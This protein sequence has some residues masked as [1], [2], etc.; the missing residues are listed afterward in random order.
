MSSSSSSS[1]ARHMMDDYKVQSGVSITNDMLPNAPASSLLIV[2]KEAPSLWEKFQADPF[3][4]IGCFV[5]A[6]ILVGG[7]H[8]FWK[9]ESKKS[10]KWMRARVASQGITIGVIGL[11]FVYNQQ[12]KLPELRQNRLN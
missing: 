3:P 11:G 6:A 1:G 5:T 4:P 7:L 9:G 2:Q 12:R 8:S 10:Q